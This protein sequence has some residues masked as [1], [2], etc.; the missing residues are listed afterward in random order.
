MA[1]RQRPEEVDELLSRKA[2]AAIAGEKLRDRALVYLESS[3][4][5]N[6]IKI[7]HELKLKWFNQD[8]VRGMILTCLL[9]ANTYQKQE[10][11]FASKYF[12][13]V[14]AYLAYKTKDTSL[15]A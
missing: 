2:G 7:L 4:N 1:S 6:A 9:L 11:F 8:T 14:A 12:G 15:N 10:L 3:D 13:L 5:A